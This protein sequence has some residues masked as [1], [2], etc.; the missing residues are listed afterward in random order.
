MYNR[1]KRFGNVVS[2][3]LSNNQLQS[4]G[5]RKENNTSALNVRNHVMSNVLYSIS[6]I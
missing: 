3:D 2:W 1:L 5:E 6:H 4:D